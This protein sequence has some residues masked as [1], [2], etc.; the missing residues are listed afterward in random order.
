MI[1]FIKNI[2][3]SS[4]E[5]FI[6]Y[7]YMIFLDRRP[8]ANGMSHYINKLSDGVSRFGVL[9]DILESKEYLS[10]DLT[11]RNDWS[12]TLPK[13][14]NS[15]FYPSANLSFVI[16][17][18]VRSLDKTLPDWMTFA[19]LRLSAAQVGKDTDPYQ[20]Y[21]TYSFFLSRLKI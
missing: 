19:K 12:S 21:N 2:Y 20:L 8:D 17:D 13:Q 15:F 16:S 4:P 3:R 6:H 9:V 18:F 14:N 1:E 5:D 7:A 11:A 10:L